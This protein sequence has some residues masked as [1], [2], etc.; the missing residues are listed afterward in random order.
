MRHFV[1][2]GNLVLEQIG[3]LQ[4]PGSPVHHLFGQDLPQPHVARTDDLSFHGE[5]IERLPA[6]V[7]RPDVG[8]RDQT[9]LHIDVD[10]SHV[11]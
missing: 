4:V 10:F 7:S 6:I 2:G 1:N 3:V 8:A 9:R 5:W 11:G